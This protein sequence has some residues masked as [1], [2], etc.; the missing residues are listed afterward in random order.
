MFRCNTTSYLISDQL[1]KYVDRYEFLDMDINLVKFHKN[2]INSVGFWDFLYYSLCVSVSVSFGDIAPN[3]SCTRAIAIIELLFCLA[4]I[5]VIV[6]KL[7]ESINKK[8]ED[9][10]R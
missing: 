7:N 4:L 8:D 3:N 10:Y 5:G 9:K 2:R 1:N 6:D